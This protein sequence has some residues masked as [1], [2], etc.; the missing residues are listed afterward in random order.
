MRSNGLQPPGRYLRFARP[1]A[2]D[3]CRAPIRHMH[4]QRTYVRTCRHHCPDATGPLVAGHVVR[5]TRTVLDARARPLLVDRSVRP[6]ARTACPHAHHPT[7]ATECGHASPMTY[8]APP[9]RC[10]V[11]LMHQLM[12]ALCVHACTHVGVRAC[13]E[14]RRFV[15][16]KSFG[17]CNSPRTRPTCK[18]V[19]GEAHSPAG[20]RWVARGCPMASHVE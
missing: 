13:V 9:G 14:V 2:R 3:R 7:S 4:G 20:Q 1:C 15:P 8:R 17:A 10:Q 5:A 18:H 11:C 6:R 12:T 19:I 16:T